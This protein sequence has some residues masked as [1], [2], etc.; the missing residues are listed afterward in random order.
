MYSCQYRVSDK[1]L[2]E[3]WLSELIIVEDDQN[4]FE[5]T[6]ENL[7]PETEYVIQVVAV[8]KDNTASISNSIKV[9]TLKAGFHCKLFYFNKKK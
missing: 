6:L 7:T 1:P 9:V 3:I 2:T 8:M 5:V 4:T